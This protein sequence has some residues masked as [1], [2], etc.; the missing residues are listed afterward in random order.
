MSSGTPPTRVAMEGTLQAMASSAARPKDSSWLGMSKR[1][2]SGEQ[3]VDALLLAEKVDAGVD[4]EVVGQPLGGGAIGA[5]ADQHQL[6]G[7]FAG[8]TRRRP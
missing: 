6:R 8:H 1:S 4:A 5:V 2:A 7:D 3:L